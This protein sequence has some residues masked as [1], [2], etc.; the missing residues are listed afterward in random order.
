MSQLD[1]PRAQVTWDGMGFALLILDF[2]AVASTH[3]WEAE[4]V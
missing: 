2:D 3:K 1:I 4:H